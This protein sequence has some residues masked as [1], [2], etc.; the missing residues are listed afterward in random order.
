MTA[1]DRMTPELILKVEEWNLICVQDNCTPIYGF[2]KAPWVSLNKYNCSSSSG[3]FVIV[4]K[5]FCLCC[6]PWTSTSNF[7]KL[8]RNTWNARGALEGGVEHC[9]TILS[10]ERWCLCQM[11]EL[12]AFVIQ[13]QHLFCWIQAFEQPRAPNCITFPLNPAVSSSPSFCLDTSQKF[14]SQLSSGF[15]TFSDK[16]QVPEKLTVT[17]SPTSTYHPDLNFVKL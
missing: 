7:N 1:V 10:L 2:S 16:S 6:T 12:F 13:K 17:N 14:A 3:W 11:V 8:E 5:R 4:P 9:H 15:C